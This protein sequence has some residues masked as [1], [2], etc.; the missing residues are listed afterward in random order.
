MRYPH[1][2]HHLRAQGGPYSARLPFQQR[3]PA[4][5][6]LSPY[7]FAG[8]G[9]HQEDSAYPGRPGDPAAMDLQAEP[10]APGFPQ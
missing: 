4:Q 1:H 5:Q 2:C 10:I 8:V 6:E 9:Y 7:S 3:L